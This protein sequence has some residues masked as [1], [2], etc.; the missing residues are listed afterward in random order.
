MTA[1]HT[2]EIQLGTMEEENGQDL[3]QARPSRM[4]AVYGLVVREP[5]PFLAVE[6]DITGIHCRHATSGPEPPT[7]PTGKATY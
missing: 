6:V 3:N 2:T 1:T 5:S 7:V 4:K